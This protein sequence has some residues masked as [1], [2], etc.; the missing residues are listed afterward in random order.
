MSKF[1]LRGLGIAYK[2]N[3]LEFFIVSFD[4]LCGNHEKVHEFSFLITRIANPNYH[5]SP[6]AQECRCFVN[7]PIVASLHTQKSRMVNGRE[8][9]LLI[10]LDAGNQKICMIP[11]RQ[12]SRNVDL[13]VQTPAKDDDRRMAPV[14]KFCVSKASITFVGI[15]SQRVCST[16]RLR[17]RVIACSF[18]HNR[19]LIVVIDEK[20]ETL[21]PSEV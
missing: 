12:E 2:N 4:K 16:V 15:L 10:V 6:C 11:G 9:L 14:P 7:R 1:A 8:L 13:P 18:I 19:A 5:H 17:K 20:G 21:F 3:N